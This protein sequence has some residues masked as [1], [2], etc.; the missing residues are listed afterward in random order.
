MNL[1]DCLVCAIAL[2]SAPEADDMVDRYPVGGSKS[3]GQAYAEAPAS[4]AR[5]PRAQASRY[6]PG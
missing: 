4:S 5:K 2:T 3:A 1:K 6:R